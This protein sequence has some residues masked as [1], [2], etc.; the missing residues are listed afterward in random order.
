MTKLPA[1]DIEV[2]AGLV[3]ELDVLACRSAV[4]MTYD[5]TVAAD[6][7]YL[8]RVSSVITGRH[9]V[10]DLEKMIKTVRNSPIKTRLAAKRAQ[11]ATKFIRDKYEADGGTTITEWGDGTF[12]NWLKENLL[13][14]IQQFMAIFAACGI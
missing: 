3:D 12:L 14:L 13:P 8:K 6:P 2:K 5:E 1:C 4:L 7:N 11:K 10:K 9:K